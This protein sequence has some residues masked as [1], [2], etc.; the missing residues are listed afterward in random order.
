MAAILGY[1]WPIYTGGPM[2]WA[3]TVGLPRIVV[4]LRELEERLG[5]EFKPSALLE[6]MAAEGTT[7]TRG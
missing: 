5:E 3:D 4:K 6:R 2:F 7:F 1:N